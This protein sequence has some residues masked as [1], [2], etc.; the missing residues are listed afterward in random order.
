MA[1]PAASPMAL[2]KE[3]T[4]SEASVHGHNGDRWRRDNPL[5]SKQSSHQAFRRVC[6]GIIVQEKRDSILEA[7][8]GCPGQ[9]DAAARASEKDG[10]GHCLKEAQ[11]SGP[12]DTLAAM[13]DKIE[14]AVRVLEREVDW[15]PALR[16]SVAYL[17]SLKF[18]A[19][20]MTDLHA[21]LFAS[22]GTDYRLA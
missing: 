1:S 4:R 16:G 20:G 8:V 15:P 13:P 11:K 17:S 2:G 6:V 12:D 19:V 7:W 5:G 10:R 21:M 9:A 22:R 14:L 18:D 3:E